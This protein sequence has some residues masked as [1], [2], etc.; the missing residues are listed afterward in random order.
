MNWS[1]VGAFVVGVAV[2]LIAAGVTYIIL[3]LKKVAP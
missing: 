2:G 3:R 1:L